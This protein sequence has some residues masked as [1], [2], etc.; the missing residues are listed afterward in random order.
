MRMSDVEWDWII[1]DGLPALRI[2]GYAPT[3][4]LFGGGGGGAEEDVR[5]LGTVWDTTGC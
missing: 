4:V 5:R 3:R 1:A 2:G